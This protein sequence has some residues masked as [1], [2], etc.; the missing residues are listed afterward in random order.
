VQAGKKAVLIRKNPSPEEQRLSG[1][2]R[3]TGF[4]QVL[5]AQVFGVTVDELRAASRCGARTALARQVAMYLAHITFGH[6]MAEVASAF[7]RDRSTA[8]YACHHVE[9]LRDDP[10][11][12][13]KLTLLE[14]LLREAAKIEV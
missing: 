3:E 8:S 2:R 13:G 7:G 10:G 9:D 5:V 11:L 14:E 4:A 12:D 1:W 6:S